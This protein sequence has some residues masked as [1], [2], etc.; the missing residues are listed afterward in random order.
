MMHME[1]K[2][3]DRRTGW[4]WA[5]ANHVSRQSYKDAVGPAR[6]RGSPRHITEMRSLRAC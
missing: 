2:A 1:D 5:H 4:A 3:T 6:S